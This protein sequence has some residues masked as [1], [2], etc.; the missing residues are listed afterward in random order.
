MPAL[1]PW[2]AVGG[3]LFI[4]A[5]ALIAWV[6]FYLIFANGLILEVLLNILRSV[7][8]PGTTHSPRPEMLGWVP[9]MQAAILL[10][11]AAGIP[12]GLAIFWRGRRKVLLL[13]F[14]AALTLG[15]VCG[16]YAVFLLI[17]SS[18]TI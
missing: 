11:G 1:S 15:A 12:A 6:L 13:S 10:A 18:I 5:W 4:I 2:P 3:A 8:V 17:S 7:M 9:A 14:A 16:A